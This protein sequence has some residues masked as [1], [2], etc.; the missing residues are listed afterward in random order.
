KVASRTQ[1]AH[2]RADVILSSV[3]NNQSSPTIHFDF[4]RMRKKF[5]QQ[6]DPLFSRKKRFLTR[7]NGYQHYDL[8]KNLDGP[9]D[10]V[11]M[12]VGERIEGAGVERALFIQ[13]RFLW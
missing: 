13:V 3:L 4:R 7:R 9:L 1:T 6:R 12:T 11:Q 8:I 2:D 5:F 10:N